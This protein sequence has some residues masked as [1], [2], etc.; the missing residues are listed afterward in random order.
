[1]IIQSLQRRKESED[2]EG[3]KQEDFEFA[4]EKVPKGVPFEDVQGLCLFSLRFSP[5]ELLEK[6][7]AVGIPSDAPFLQKPVLPGFEFPEKRL[8]KK[9][10]FETGD[11]KIL[12]VRFDPMD[13]FL[14]LGCEDGHVRVFQSQKGPQS[15]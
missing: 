2:S 6:P 10:S 15:F 13:N 12:S 1:M 8:N 4:N 7:N 14:A 9:I 3:E 11:F 5:I